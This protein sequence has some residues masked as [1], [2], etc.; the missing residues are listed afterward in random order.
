MAN[1][2]YFL[3][4]PHGLSELIQESVSL[5]SLPPL[6]SAPI[7]QKSVKKAKIKPRAMSNNEELFLVHPPVP[8]TCNRERAQTESQICV[9]KKYIP[10]PQ[11]RQKPWGD[12]AS[13]QAN[14]NSM[15]T[16]ESKNP[17]AVNKWMRDGEGKDKIVSFTEVQ[18]E[19]KDY[20]DLDEA[21][22][23]IALMESLQK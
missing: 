17:L 6:P 1:F 4:L 22:V 19:E 3:A 18:V 12:I 13:V 11:S 2:E 23:L 15:Q 21:L 8:K 14:F 10:P 16:E 20:Q 9:A 5:G 7:Q